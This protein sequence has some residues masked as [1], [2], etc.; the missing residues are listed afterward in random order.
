MQCTSLTIITY[1]CLIYTLAYVGPRPKRRKSV[2]IYCVT[3]PPSIDAHFGR[4]LPTYYA[5]ANIRIKHCGFVLGRK[6]NKQISLI[7]ALTHNVYCVDGDDV[8]NTKRRV[9]FQGINAF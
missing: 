8:Y 9:A 6:E 7:Q 1:P 4:F 3:A 5:C 2:R